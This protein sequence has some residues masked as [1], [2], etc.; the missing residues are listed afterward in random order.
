[1]SEN[2]S[3]T[4][5]KIIQ[6]RI[7]GKPSVT[8]ASDWQVDTELTRWC[9]SDHS[10]GGTKHYQHGTTLDGKNKVLPPQY[11]RTARIKYYRQST[12]ERR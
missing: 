11:H 12:S 2:E 1:M 7:S 5:L 9:N 3:V 4:G 6:H 10:V 8:D